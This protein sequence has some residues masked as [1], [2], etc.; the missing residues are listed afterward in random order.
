MRKLFIPLFC[1]L[2]FSVSQAA[3][4]NWSAQN[5]VGLANSSGAALASGS[6]VRLGY[7]T[8]S[9][10]AVI[11]A[12][13]D[14]AT[15][16][17]SWHSI[18]DTTVSTGFPGDSGIFAAVSTPTLSGAELGHQIYFWALNAPTVLGA[19]QQA[20]FYEPSSS[21]AFWNLPGSNIGSTSVD[22]GDAKSAGVYLVG[23][24]QASNP[25][26]NTLLGAGSGSVNLA[27]ISASP[28][29]SKMLLIL[30]GSAL[31]MVRRRRRI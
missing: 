24:Y 2:A 18:A 26:F 4:I 25:A 21:N 20:I 1:T 11:A 28:E 22:I 6:L 19:T 14:L 23:S 13:D 12:K 15:L 30:A 10:A 17:S 27:T 29:P 5:D 9:D 7:F 16:S 31:V 3:T 8:I